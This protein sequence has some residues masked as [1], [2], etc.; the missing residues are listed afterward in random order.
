MC[1]FGRLSVSVI[2]LHH[3]KLS[4]IAF[5]NLVL[6][7]YTVRFTSINPFR[8][9][10]TGRTKHHINVFGEELIIENAEAA[11]RKASKL[12]HSEIVDLVLFI[13]SG[14]LSSCP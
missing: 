10:V 11:L 2:P 12:T 4:L 3:L 1:V 8:I 14:S 7:S 9:K 6:Y 5:I 13:R